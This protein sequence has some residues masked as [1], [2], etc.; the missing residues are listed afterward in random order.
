MVPVF[1]AAVLG[2][3]LGYIVGHYVGSHDR[4]DPPI[5]Y[6]FYDD[7]VVDYP[8]PEPRMMEPGVMPMED[9]ASSFMLMDGSI[10]SIYDGKVIYS[11]GMHEEMEA[12]IEDCK[13]RGGYF[14]DC[15]SPCSPDSEV[16]V[17]MCALTCEF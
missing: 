13:M 6:P 2:A 14:N 16:C 1:I 15:G 11:M 8:A 9:P 10:Q 5:P 12:L 17:E 3:A 4:F 7:A